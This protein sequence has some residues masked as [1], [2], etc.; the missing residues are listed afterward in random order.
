MTDKTNN[1]STHPSKNK[2]VFS[3]IISIIL[4][5]LLVFII[6]SNIFG[7]IL[8]WSWVGVIID[9]QTGEQKTLWDWMELL[10]IPV[11]LSI[12]AYLLNKSS[13]ANEYKIAEQ[14]RENERKVADHRSEIER[15]IAKDT[16][17]Q[18]TLETYFDRMTELLLASAL[19]NSPKGDEVRIIARTRTLA[20]LR[21]LDGK[22]KGQVVQFLHELGLISG[23]EP[24]VDMSFADLDN[25]Y[26]P[27]SRLENVS[28]PY[29][30]LKNCNLQFAHLEGANFNVATLTE[31]NLG[32][33]SLNGA[34]L[35]CGLYKANMV[36]TD[37]EGAKLYKAHLGSAN[38][39][40][41]KL[42]NADLREANLKYDN[43]FMGAIGQG[44]VEYANLFNADLSDCDLSNAMID[45]VQLNSARS[46]KGAIMPD[47]QK[48]EAWIENQ[49]KAKTEKENYS[50]TQF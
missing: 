49:R 10:I 36:A 38:L 9:A 46:L 18:V 31:A 15:D 16:Q 41:A 44:T 23:K 20:V 42:V 2:D 35:R 11:V 4:I 43:P 40:N 17:R 1:N 32:G 21:E 13:K 27:Y 26:L 12:G 3:K 7:Y 47:K 50:S 22:R 29:V 28:L 19:R 5:I 34:D 6:L 30:N 14:Q 8:G 24:I 25:M 48:F 45:I 33:A 39:S 37:L